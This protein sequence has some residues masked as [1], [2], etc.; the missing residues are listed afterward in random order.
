MPKLK[1][2]E[3]RLDSLAKILEC[4]SMCVAVVCV[5]SKFLIASNEFTKNTTNDH[6]HLKL[7]IEILNYLKNVAK[8]SKF[9]ANDRDL[10]MQKICNARLSAIGKGNL[11]LSNT[12]IKEFI[13]THR[14]SLS[15]EPKKSECDKF[16]ETHVFAKSSAAFADMQR[17]YRM[18]LKIENGIK[19]AKVGKYIAITKEQLE[20]FK[21]FDQT[22]ILRIERS[23]SKVHAEMQILNQLMINNHAKPVYIGVSKLCCF[24]CHCVIKA[25]NQF[26]LDDGKTFQVKTRGSHFGQ[27]E[28]WNQPSFFFKHS[29]LKKQFRN[30]IKELYKFNVENL[31]PAITYNMEALDSESNPS[32]TSEE[33]SIK[34]NLA[35]NKKKTVLESIEQERTIIDHLNLINF[36][37]ELNNKD[38]LKDLFMISDL[39][40]AAEISKVIESFF[41][42]LLASKIIFDGGLLEKFCNSSHFPPIKQKSIIIKEIE[43]KVQNLKP[44]KIIKNTLPSCKP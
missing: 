5:N 13:T 30:K 4:K 10:L 22:Q 24:D 37:I 8:K 26:Y 35:L 11:K 33:L 36:G 2:S 1:I 9:S 6:E 7:I 44:G 19:K 3:R 29:S 38:I 43:Q 15:S 20:A 31:E 17:I 25:V 42:S 27:R 23:A 34:Y 32:E 28:E 21:D 14:L 41:A 18:I 16:V 12:V 40:N 39:S